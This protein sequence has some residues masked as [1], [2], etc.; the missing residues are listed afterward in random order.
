MLPHLPKHVFEIAVICEGFRRGKQQ[1]G[2]ARRV[3]FDYM[4]SVGCGRTSVSPDNSKC[5]PMAKPNLAI[6]K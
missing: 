2:M 3:L 1:A 4:A 6:T 5:G